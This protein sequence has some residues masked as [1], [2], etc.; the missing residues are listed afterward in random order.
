MHRL[1]IVDI[2]GKILPIL[3][4]SRIGEGSVCAEDKID[5]LSRPRLILLSIHSRG[6]CVGI[7]LVIPRYD[8]RIMHGNPAVSRVCRMLRVQPADLLFRQIIR[9]LCPLYCRRD[10]RQK[11]RS[12]QQNRQ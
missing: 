2:I 9:P 3:Q 6:G 5:F 11:E 1:V 4:I 8:R 7:P 12:H 10:S